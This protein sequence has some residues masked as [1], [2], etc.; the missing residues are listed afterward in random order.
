MLGSLSGGIKVL[1]YIVDSFDIKFDDPTTGADGGGYDGVGHLSNLNLSAGQ[2]SDPL[3]ATSQVPFYLNL[4][5]IYFSLSGD[6][7]DNYFNLEKNKFNHFKTYSSFYTKNTLSNLSA[8]E[9]N[10]IKTI[11]LTGEFIYVKLSSYGTDLSAV[12]IVTSNREDD[13]SIIVGSSGQNIVYFKTEEQ[14]KPLYLSFFKNPD[15]IHS[16]SFKKSNN[17]DYPTNFNSA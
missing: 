3:S 6:K 13:S 1:D 12:K 14:R 9:Y 5:N 7:Y 15:R 10:E 8:V 17:T 4:E 2:F 11:S 16:T